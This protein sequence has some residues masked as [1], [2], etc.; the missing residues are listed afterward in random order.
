MDK[1]SPEF[2]RCAKV[3]EMN[4]CELVRQKANRNGVLADIFFEE[5]LS[6]VEQLDI[7]RKIRVADEE[8][9]SNIS[10]EKPRKNLT[11]NA[12]LP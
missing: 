3:N 1:F 12:A 5:T 9:P 2:S 4:S 11:E 8:N 10:F 6:P 7:D